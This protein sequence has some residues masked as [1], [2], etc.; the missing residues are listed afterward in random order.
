MLNSRFS[1]IVFH[2]LLLPALFAIL[3]MPL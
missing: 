1:L 2:M 3:M